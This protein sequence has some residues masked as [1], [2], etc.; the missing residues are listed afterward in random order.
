MSELKANQSYKRQPWS[1][2]IKD[3]SSMITTLLMNNTESL[4][5]LLCQKASL[6]SLL[7]TFNV[8]CPLHEVFRADPFQSFIK[9][10]SIILGVDEQEIQNVLTNRSSE[11]SFAHLVKLEYGTNL[12]LASLT[13]N[14]ISNLACI[15]ALAE[16][17]HRE[18]IVLC[19]YYS[20]NFI[21][22]GTNIIVF[23]PR[24]GMVTN[25]PIACCLIDMNL[26][27]PLI[28]SEELVALRS[29]DQIKQ[30]M[31]QIGTDI[32]IPT[33]ENGVE[34]PRDI[35]YVELEGNE[36]Q[37]ANMGERAE[38]PFLST[39]PQ[40]YIFPHN[41]SMIL[42]SFLDQYFA[43]SIPSQ[44]NPDWYT[45]D[46]RLDMTSSV[47]PIDSNT[48]SRTH[49]IDG[50]FG[51]IEKDQFRLA[52]KYPVRFLVYPTMVDKRTLKN[53]GKNPNTVAL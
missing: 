40:Q 39:G 31:Y 30:V 26:F 2:T 36:Y 32:E 6:I 33:D 52:V 29:N 21:H 8:Q 45:S 9:T 14:F 12:Q 48:F 47:N 27:H 13:T 20:L 42:E 28:F 44:I 16:E 46:V 50:W 49:D 4:N 41:N 23:K 15:G 53:I 10:F 11:N 25:S 34:V 37:A 19:D 5:C 17:F 38:E 43:D 24:N 22:E 1:G 3:F 35:E 18:I 7:N 51:F